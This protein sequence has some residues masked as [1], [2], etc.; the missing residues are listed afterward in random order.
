METHDK[1]KDL[2]RQLSKE[3]VHMAHK[4]MKSCLT[5]LVIREYQP[6]HNGY[7]FIPTTMVIIKTKLPQTLV[8]M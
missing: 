8:R 2:N 7:N 5:S 6:N 1:T 4:H 3:D